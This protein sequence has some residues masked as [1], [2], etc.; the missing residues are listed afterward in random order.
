M[1]FGMCQRSSHEE[2]GID[3]LFCT[4]GR[5]SISDIFLESLHRTFRRG[6]A[7]PEARIDV[8]S[9]LSVFYIFSKGSTKDKVRAIF[10]LFDFNQNGTMSQDEVTIMFISSF[11]GLCG[12]LRVPSK[13]IE[14]TCERM[15]FDT[16]QY[17]VNEY[18]HRNSNSINQLEFLEFL[19][20]RIDT[21]DDGISAVEI[22]RFF[23]RV[24]G[25]VG[26]RQS[27]VTTLCAQ[28]NSELTIKYDDE[29]DD[30]DIERYEGNGDEFM[31][32]KPWLGAVKGPSR[33]V[34]T[35]NNTPDVSLELDWVYGY[36]S[37]DVRNNL[38][39][40]DDT[41]EIVFPCAAVVVLFNP[42]V[43]SQHFLQGHDD[44]IVSL[45]VSSDGTQIVTG[46]TGRYPCLIVWHAKTRRLVMTLRSRSLRRA[47]VA[48]SFSPCGSRVVAVGQDD[49]HTVHIFDVKSGTCIAKSPTERAR[50]MT[51]LFVD[52]ENV[53]VAGVKHIKHL[54][55]RNDRKNKTRRRVQSKRLL[56][57]KIGSRTILCCTCF[58]D[59]IVCGTSTG[60]LVV[61]DIKQKARHFTK[62]VRL[63][64]NSVLNDEDAAVNAIYSNNNKLCAGSKHGQV[65]ILNRTFE[66]VRTHEVISSSPL[67]SVRSVCLSQDETNVLMGT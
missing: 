37:Y 14:P 67:C 21:D 44:D 13:K 38:R 25:V 8:L 22:V 59:M 48:V 57:G 42:I 17:K 18:P 34:P 27:N 24:S 19:Q 51:C 9:L 50:V 31:A 40:L 10:S 12:Y 54:I 46:E 43:R 7:G 56:F 2:N 29:I 3:R 30:Y 49:R 55:F 26:A 41:K 33:D 28:E 66:I 39:Y 15:A 60:E 5:K 1:P 36:R 4:K 64:T 47:V 63:V 65:W 23:Q 20:Y 53:I 62:I 52:P 58:Q 61:W 45:D 35:S 6:P 32:I 16:F 11:Y